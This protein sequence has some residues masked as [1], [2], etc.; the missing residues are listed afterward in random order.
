MSLVEKDTDKPLT[1]QIREIALSGDVSLPP[2]PE[3][4]MRVLTLLGDQ[5]RVDV[6]DLAEAVHSDPAIAA[7]L[8]RMA[9]SAF[10]GGLQS[11]TDLDRAITRLGL[12]RVGSL[13][14]TLVHKGQFESAN[15]FQAAMLQQMWDHAV[16]TALA[17][18]HLAR[19]VGSDGEESYLAGLFHDIGKLLV[20]KA[21]DHL[22]ATHKD[23]ELMPIILDEVLDVAHADLGHRILSEWGM[24]ESICRAVLA[25][26]DEIDDV[27]DGLALRVQAA[28]AISKKI[29]SHPRPEPDLVLGDVPAIERLG[30]TEIE[31][32]AL[33]VDLEDEITALKQML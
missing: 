12:T 31:V 25:H 16:V 13:V 1:E 15:K 28:D 10:Y 33:T 8:L 14:T 20:L 5:D 24:A 30:L 17:A 22:A 26:H 19:L 27:E 7:S 32:A 2:L 11:V 4:G 21:I 29:G 6:S 23:F 18:R 9:N 3:V